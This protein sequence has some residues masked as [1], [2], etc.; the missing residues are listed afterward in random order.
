MLDRWYIDHAVDIRA[1]QNRFSMFGGGTYAKTKNDFAQ[2]QGQGFAFEILEELAKP[3][4]QSDS[5]FRNDL[6]T[7]KDMWLEKLTQ[8]KLY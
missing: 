8:Q 3:D 5:S 4:N 7:L 2:Q 1:A 6:A